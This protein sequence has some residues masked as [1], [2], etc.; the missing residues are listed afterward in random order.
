MTTTCPTKTPEYTT[1]GK[2]ITFRA[3]DGITIPKAVREVAFALAV[4]VVIVSV[5]RETYMNY[6]CTPAESFYGV[7]TLVQQHAL[8]LKIPLKFPRQRIYYGRVPEAFANWNSLFQFEYVRTY[9]EKVAE[10]IRILA[11]GLNLTTTPDPFCCSMFQPRWEELPLREVYVNVPLG[12]QYRIEVYWVKPEPLTDACGTVFGGSSFK[13]DSDIDEG[14]PPN[15]IFPNI[16]DDPND[17][18]AGL[19]E[20]TPDSEQGAFS[21][22]KTSN[23]D[24]RDPNNTPQSPTDAGTT[25][26]TLCSRA[27]PPGTTDYGCGEEIV[28]NSFRGCNYVLDPPQNGT[29]RPIYIK[30]ISG[31]TNYSILAT[32]GLEIYGFSTQFVPN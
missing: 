15:G 10:Q 7:A 24:D 6:E 28:T 12:T 16:A 11:E 23:I 25:I 17:P 3:D 5:P 4:D 27:Y 31:L 14:L 18:Y 2:I 22:S 21:N 8:D 13:T 1:E 9:F 30:D 20:P 19:P 29:S 26:I 32:N